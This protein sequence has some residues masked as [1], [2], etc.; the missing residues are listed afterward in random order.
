M[1]CAAYLH[2]DPAGVLL[3]EEWDQL[4]PSQL[5]PERHISGL[6]DSVDLRDGFGGIRPIVVESLVD[7]SPLLQVVTDP[8]LAH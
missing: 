8:Y 3:L 6:V 1:R 5:T 7:G 4:A 2:D